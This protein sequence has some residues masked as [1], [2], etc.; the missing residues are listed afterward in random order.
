MKYKGCWNCQYRLNNPKGQKYYPDCL[1]TEKTLCTYDIC[2]LW[3][4][5]TEE[6]EIEYKMM[7]RAEFKKAHDFCTGDTV[8]LTDTNDVLRL[9]A[10]IDPIM[11]ELVRK[12]V[13]EKQGRTIKRT[14][15]PSCGGNLAA[16]KVGQNGLCKCEYCNT[17]TYVW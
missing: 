14:K 15:C 10:H 13:R 7:S 16:D 8:Y 5:T 12:D 1:W 4:Q 3:K 9:N 6:P 11:V 17:L 2:H